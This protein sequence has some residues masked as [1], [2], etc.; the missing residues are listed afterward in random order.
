MRNRACWLISAPWSQV[1]D[2]RSC[3]GKVV[4]VLVIA[5]VGGLSEQDQR[6]AHGLVVQAPMRAW[7]RPP[8]RL[9]GAK[10]AHGVLAMEARHGRELV[11][12]FSTRWLVP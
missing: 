5:S 11:R 10:H 6:L 8:L 3:S 2:C 12:V 4:I 1:N 7:T 9:S